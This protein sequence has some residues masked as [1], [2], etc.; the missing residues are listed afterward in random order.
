MDVLVEEN[1]IKNNGFMGEL[2]D[3]ADLK[4]SG[5]YG[6]PGSSPGEATE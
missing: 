5:Q 3:P 6:R 2:V 1:I 4:S